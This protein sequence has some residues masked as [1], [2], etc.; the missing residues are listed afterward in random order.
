VDYRYLN[1]ITVK[2]KYPVPV[3]D[4]LLD[5]LAFI[6]SDSSRVRNTKQRSKH[7]VDTMTFI[8]WPSDSLVHPDHFRKQ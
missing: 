2:A 4:E 7:I 5:E 8:S 3:I 6:K 1:A